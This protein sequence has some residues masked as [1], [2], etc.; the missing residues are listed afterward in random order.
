MSIYETDN[1][2]HVRQSHQHPFLAH[3][4][5]RKA[6]YPHQPPFLLGDPLFAADFAT[7]TAM[8]DGVAQGDWQV[9]TAAARWI[10]TN[11]FLLRPRDVPE[12][13]REAFRAFAGGG[14]CR[15]EGF[16]AFDP[17]VQQ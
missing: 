1:R 13:H 9:Y 4:R 7:F 16:E 5:E 14:K 11:G 6:Q 15:E 3:P 8:F 17:R 12:A 2:G 10:T